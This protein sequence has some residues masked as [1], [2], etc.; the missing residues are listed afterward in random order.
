MK[1]TISSS[2][3]FFMRLISTRAVAGR[4]SKNLPYLGSVRS[5]MVCMRL[6]APR[7]LRRRF[8]SSSQASA[9]VLAQGDQHDVAILIR[10]FVKVIQKLTPRSTRQLCR[11]RRGERSARCQTSS[12]LSKAKDSGRADVVAI[13][14][15][16]A[17][18]ASFWANSLFA[19]RTNEYVHAGVVRPRQA[20]LPRTLG[21]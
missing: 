10:A 12:P 11:L 21:K 14:T 8:H 17:T 4:C 15:E 13:R 9:D 6:A 18:V 20:S 19:C 7:L 16:Y 5:S 2:T 3:R 1:S